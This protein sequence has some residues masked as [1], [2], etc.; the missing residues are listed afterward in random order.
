MHKRLDTYDLESIEYPAHNQKSVCKLASCYLPALNFHDYGDMV[1][2]P[3]YL[4]ANFTHL[5]FLHY[6]LAQYNCVPSR[7]SKLAFCREKIAYTCPIS[8]LYLSYGN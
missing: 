5:H 2:C 3:V 4:T 1:R 8:S 6:A 7:V